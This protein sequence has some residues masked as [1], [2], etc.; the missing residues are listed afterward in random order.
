MLEWFN[1]IKGSKERIPEKYS[2]LLK[3]LTI[4]PSY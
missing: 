4:N 1:E 3:I 2:L